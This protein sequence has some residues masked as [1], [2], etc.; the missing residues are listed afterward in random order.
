MPPSAKSARTHVCSRC[1]LVLDRD[2]N[3][4]LNIL[5]LGKKQS[6][7]GRAPQASTWA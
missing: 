7:A 1:G 5:R 4:A 3:A 2:Q 6:G